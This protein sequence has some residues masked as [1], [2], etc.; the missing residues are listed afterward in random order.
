MKQ[1][2][3]IS[4]LLQ[5]L[6]KYNFINVD[7]FVDKSIHDVFKCHLQLIIEEAKELEYRQHK[8]TFYI[9]F[10]H[11]FDNDFED[12]LSALKHFKNTFETRFEQ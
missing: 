4:N 12:T 9:S 3:A 5:E 6:I 2:T 1:Q 10:N 8:E 7:D 11:F